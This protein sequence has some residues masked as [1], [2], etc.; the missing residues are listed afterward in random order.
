MHDTCTILSIF[1]KKIEQNEIKSGVN[2]IV[3]DYFMT[4]KV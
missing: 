2:E 3:I 4:G 1:H